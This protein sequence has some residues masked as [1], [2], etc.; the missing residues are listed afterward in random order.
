MVKDECM[1]ET[2]LPIQL[3]KSGS[4]AFYCEY[5][6]CTGKRP[7]YAA[8]L[9]RIEAVNIDS[10]AGVDHT[11]VVAIQRGHCEALEMREKEVMEGRAL[12]YIDRAELKRATQLRLEAQ[13]EKLQIN[14][15][16]K[17]KLLSGKSTVS[18]PVKLVEKPKGNAT[19]ADAI[20]QKIRRNSIDAKIDS[21]KSQSDILVST[22]SLSGD[23]VNHPIIQSGMSLAEIA[24]TLNSN[25]EKS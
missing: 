20:N 10:T 12:F 24:K 11:C 16:K 8:C 6:P 5:C 4:N 23:D 17:S 25:Q 19:L 13:G 1:I 7:N 2:K 9:N 22:Y 15:V 14:N 21:V 3:S 18:N